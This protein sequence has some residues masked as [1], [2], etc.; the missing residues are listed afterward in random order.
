M[1]LALALAKVVA[2]VEEPARAGVVSS[3]DVANTTAPVPVAPVTAAAK[4]ALVG[5]ARKVAIPVPNPV[6]PASGTLDAAI[7]PLPVTPS[8]APVPTIIAAVVLVPP[9]I[10]LNAPPP[11]V[12]FNTVPVNERLVP[13]V[14]VN[15]A[16][17][18]V[19]LELHTIVP[20]G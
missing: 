10:A 14:Q 8:E 13:S 12:A 6:T 15:G 19:A 1:A 2:P 16:W 20:G 17:V 4:F 5:V 7:V 18:T 11:P 9:V 3:G